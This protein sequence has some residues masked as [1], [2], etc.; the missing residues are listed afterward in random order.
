[1]KPTYEQLEQQLAA[2]RQQ[3]E[4]LAA[5]NVTRGD[6]IER[7]I[8]QYGAAG[9]HAI[10]NSMNP[11]SALMYDAMQVMR[12]TTA[13]DAAI[14]EIRA[15]GVDMAISKLESSRYGEENDMAVL[16]KF[17]QQLRGEAK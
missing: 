15:Q 10:Q 6:I 12:R 13:T 5:E 2:A 3:I 11:A 14:A 7:M 16:R 17:A 9:L 8:G 1:M 4:A